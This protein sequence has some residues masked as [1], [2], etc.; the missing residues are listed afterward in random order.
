MRTFALTWKPIHTIYMASV[1]TMAGALLMPTITKGQG[2]GGQPKFP[3]LESM[4]GEGISRTLTTSRTFDL[5]NPFFK[6]LGTN[7]RTCATCHPVA[8]GATITPDYA[9]QVFAATDGLDPLFAP[10]DAA[11][12]PKGDMSTVQARMNNCSLLLTK[13][14]IR[15]GMPV[16]ANAEFTLVGVDDPY[17]YASAKDVSCFRRPLPATNLRFLSS[18]MWDGRELFGKSSVT[19]ALKSQIKDAVLGHMQGISAPSDS[20]VQQILDFETHLYTSQVYD[21]SVGRLDL[22]QIGAGPEQLVNLPFSP[23]LNDAF[24]FVRN[25]QRFNQNVFDFYDLWLPNNGP[26]G[27]GNPPPSRGP[28]PTP[29]QASVARGERIFNTRQFDIVDVPGLN[30]VLNKKRI[31]ATCSSCHSLTRVGSNSLPLLMN[32][33]VADGALR[34]PDL[35]LYTFKNKKTGQTLQTTDPGAALTTGKWADMGKFK[36]PSLRGLETQSPYFHNGMSGELLDIIDFYNTRFLIDL[37][38]QEKADLKAFLMT[39]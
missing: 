37:T 25:Q 2:M 16:P 15:V 9:Q 34:T 28:I 1:A 31:P 39:L 20:V 14:L 27:P 5:N 3:F 19:D 32:T 6:P 29:Q 18:V 8:Q 10:V 13:G 24:G 35:P 30:D 17:N 33:G 7:G 23:G 36:V 12:N 22:P 11:N 38:D 4:N 26:K 21:D